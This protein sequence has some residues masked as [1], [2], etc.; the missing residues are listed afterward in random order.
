MTSITASRNADPS[1]I[2]AAG[3]SGLIAQRLLLAATVLARSNA[4]NEADAARD[5]A[6]VDFGA[7]DDALGDFDEAYPAIAAAAKHRPA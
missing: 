1:D 4:L 7:A 5:R 3:V 2:P 6:W